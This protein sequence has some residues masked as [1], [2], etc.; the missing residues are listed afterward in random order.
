MYLPAV[1]TQDHMIQCLQTQP[2]AVFNRAKYGVCKLGNR[3]INLWELHNA[4]VRLGGYKEVVD[5]K[6]LNQ[7]TKNIGRAMK[8]S[9]NLKV[10]T[11]AISL[12]ED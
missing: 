8:Y 4:V 3:G 6:S 7:H 9:L 2:P 10:F 1:A 5:P 11:S 12:K